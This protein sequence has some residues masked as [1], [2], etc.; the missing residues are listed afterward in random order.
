METVIINQWELYNNS[1]MADFTLRI[2]NEKKYGSKVKAKQIEKE[3]NLFM[4]KRG[5]KNGF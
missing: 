2:A 1:R 3:M 5:I 4:K